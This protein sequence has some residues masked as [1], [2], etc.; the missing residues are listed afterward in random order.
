MCAGHTNQ[1]RPKKSELAYPVQLTFCIDVR[2]LN[3]LNVCPAALFYKNRRHW[4][5]QT[6]DSGLTQ[7][8]IRVQRSNSVDFGYE[9]V[10]RA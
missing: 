6:S 8:S 9:V 2:L 10:V 1:L 4:D 3:A 5:Q 7:R